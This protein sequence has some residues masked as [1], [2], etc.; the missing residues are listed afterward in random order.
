MEQRIKIIIKNLK[1]GFAAFWCITLALFI[2][3]EADVYYTGLYAHDIKA[4]YY[5]ETITILITALCI[6]VSLKTFSWI[7]QRRINN[8]TITTALKQYLIWSSV[9]LLLLLI[10]TL[11]GIF[12]YYLTL[13]NTGALCA[14]MGITASFFCVPSEDKL[15][16]DLHIDKTK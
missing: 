6:P 7:L 9:R 1:I 4:S 16:K 8:Q 15:R 5:F 3:G 12:C 2:M 10:V 11:T 13:S 14:L